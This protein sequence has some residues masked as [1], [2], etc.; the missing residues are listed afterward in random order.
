MQNSFLRLRTQS[1]SKLYNKKL[2]K[3]YKLLIENKCQYYNAYFMSLNFTIVKNKTN[4]LV[5]AYKHVFMERSSYDA[6]SV[7]VLQLVFNR[8]RDFV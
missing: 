4:L 1:L 3:D 2:L 6:K 7:L 8:S 5:E